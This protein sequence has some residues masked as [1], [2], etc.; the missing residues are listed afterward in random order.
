MLYLTNHVYYTSKNTAVFCQ[1]LNVFSILYSNHMLLKTVHSG[2][3]PRLGF[4]LSIVVYQAS[5]I[6][7]SETLFK[8]SYVPCSVI[9]NLFVH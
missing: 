3:Y 6:A 9:R 1:R 2:Q 4:A 8:L 5:A 7:D